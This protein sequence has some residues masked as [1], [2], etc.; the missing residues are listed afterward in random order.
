MQDSSGGGIHVAVGRGACLEVGRVLF[1]FYVGC[2]GHS[3]TVCRHH[4]HLQ[5]K[6]TVISIIRVDNEPLQY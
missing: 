2:G 4:R 5:K 1:L 6:I 3:C